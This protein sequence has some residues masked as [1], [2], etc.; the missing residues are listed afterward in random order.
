[1][2]CF[3]ATYQPSSSRFRRNPELLTAQGDKKAASRGI[4]E[5]RRRRATALLDEICITAAIPYN[6]GYCQ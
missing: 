6:V 2:L 3:A 5:K 4:L 1:L